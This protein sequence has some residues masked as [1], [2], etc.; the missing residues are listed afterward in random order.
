LT[1]RDLNK[2]SIATRGRMMHFTQIHGFL[3]GWKTFD[4]LQINNILDN[5]EST[6]VLVSN[7]NPSF[8]RKLC[9][10]FVKK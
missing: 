8:I 3:Y 10:K 1:K 5:H 6:I 2:H 7:I 4:G 9:E